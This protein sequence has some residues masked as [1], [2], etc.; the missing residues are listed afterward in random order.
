MQPKRRL[1]LGEFLSACFSEDPLEQP[2][3]CNWSRSFQGGREIG[4]EV[5]HG[6]DELARHDEIAAG[7]R[8]QGVLGH[9]GGRDDELD[10]G[11][12]SFADRG[13]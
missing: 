1:D 7:Q 5:R 4:D 3:F 10:L 9:A 8:V 13:L 12:A 6:G 2:G 11:G